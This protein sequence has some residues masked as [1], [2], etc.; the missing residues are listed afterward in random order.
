MTTRRQTLRQLALASLAL[1]GLPARAAW[2]ERPVTIV[3]PFPAGSAADA[4]VRVLAEKLKT[5]LGTAVVID[6]KPGA[7]GIL[8]TNA[9]VRAAPDGYTCLLYTSR[10]V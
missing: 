7:N 8:G 5:V 3:V 10:C 4:N 2:P 6:N 9:V 1:A